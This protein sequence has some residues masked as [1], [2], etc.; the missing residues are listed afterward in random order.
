[1]NNTALLEYCMAK[2]GAEQSDQNQ[3]Q[4]SQI[5]VGDVMFAMVCE[6]QGR[7]ALAVK[8][9]PELAESLREHHPEIVAC[10]G[11]NK[12]HWNTVFLDGN[13]PNSQFYTLIDS[14]YQLVLEG[15]PEHVRQELRA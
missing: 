5:K 1:M 11:L 8:S 15:L 4:A 13:L 9:S 7:P 6:V 10:D 14:S 2:P 12:A 3:W